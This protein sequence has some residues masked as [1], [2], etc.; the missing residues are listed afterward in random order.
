VGGL[1]ADP[2]VSVDAGQLT[3]YLSMRAFERER[4]KVELLQA[5]VVEKQRLRREVAL[6]KENAAIREAEAR[7]RAEAEEA[8]RLAA[9]EAARLA[10][11]AEAA[12]RAAEEAL[13][14]ATEA[15]EAERQAAAEAERQAAEAERLAAEEAER[16]AAEA[17]RLARDAADALAAEAEA[18]EA[19]KSAAQ[20]AAEEAARQKAL[21]AP[22][23]IERRPLPDPLADP[24]SAITN[25]TEFRDLPQLQFDDLPGVDDPIRS[26]IAPDG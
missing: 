14:Q 19:G 18:R 5:G 16:Q 3:N 2:A 21:Q 11:E 1:L 7:A 10:A 8:A 20:R 15:A 13:R 24:A 9:E 12:Q 23:T 26:L 4:R 6:L 17:D 22:P 25:E